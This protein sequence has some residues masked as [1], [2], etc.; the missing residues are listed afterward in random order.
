MAGQ[1]FEARGGALSHGLC[2]TTI[3]STG[4]VAFKTKMPGQS[5]AFLAYRSLFSSR[6]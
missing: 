1:T 6:M 2:K 4:M 3:P 5:Q